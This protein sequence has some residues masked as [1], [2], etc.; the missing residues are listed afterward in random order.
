VG[1]ALGDVARAEGDAV[2]D[3]A[4]GDG[5]GEALAAGA[6]VSGGLPT[7]AYTKTP[8]PATITAT[9]A[10]VT[11]TNLRTTRLRCS[12][13]LASSRRTAARLRLTFRCDMDT[14]ETSSGVTI[15]GSA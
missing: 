1:D 11:Y 2:G 15:K 6:V 12:R 9:R 3:V 4:E 7:E 14:P 5:E 13:N 10:A 8:V